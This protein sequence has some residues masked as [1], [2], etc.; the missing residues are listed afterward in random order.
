M[1]STPRP[2]KRTGSRDA[3]ADAPEGKRDAKESRRAKAYVKE[4]GD[5]RVSVNPTFLE[6][7]SSPSDDHYVWAYHVR[8]ENAGNE[9][10]QL[11]RRHWEITDSS[12]RRQ[13]VR[14]PGVVG[15]EPV[16]APGES[17]EYTSSAMIPTPVGSM[18]GNYFLITDDGSEFAVAIPVFSLAKPNIVN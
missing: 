15:E 14:G 2:A 17:F 10:V 3:A 13:E 1:S 7:Q 16:L 12:G 6:E 18:Q 4:T 11:R 5:I 8:I 9:T